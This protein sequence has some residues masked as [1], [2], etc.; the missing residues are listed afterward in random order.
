[1]VRRGV[2]AKGEL[3]ARARV[4]QL[5]LAREGL[6]GGE[7][8]AV[9][10]GRP[11]DRR[12]RR[13]AAAQDVSEGPKQVGGSL[14]ETAVEIYRSEKALQLLHRAGPGMP[15][16]GGD[17]LGKRGDAGGGHPV[18]QEI[19]GLCRKLTFLAID[20]ET[21]RLE[22]LKDVSDVQEML[23]AGGLPMRTS[24]K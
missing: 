9:H 7:E 4:D 18:A 2:D 5:H 21:G 11:G 10:L 13:R 15:P 8:G 24:S 16:K 19:Q 3:G 6:P 23:L 14:D 1:M 20:Y 17:S 12:R 22:P